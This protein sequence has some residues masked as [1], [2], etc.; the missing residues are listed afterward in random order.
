MLLNLDTRQ[1]TPLASGDGL[2]APFWS[3]DSRYVYSQ[4]TLAPEQPIFRVAIGGAKK[5]KKE[6]TVGSKQIPQ[7]NFVGYVLAGLAPDDAPIA[8]VIHTNSDIYALGV[9]LP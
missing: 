6:R 7:S 3:R 8:T 9:D 4:E 1:W 5:E 2:S